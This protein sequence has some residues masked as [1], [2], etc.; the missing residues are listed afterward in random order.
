MADVQ[1]QVRQTLDQFKAQVQE[2]SQGVAALEDLM[3]QVE[4]G[5]TLLEKD[6]QTH[7]ADLDKLFADLQP[8]IADLSTEFD[9]EHQAL[10][11]ATQ[12][13]DGEFG[14]DATTLE[15]EVHQL[16]SEI[17]NYQHALDEHDS[18]LENTH[19]DLHSKAQEMQSKVMQHG[20]GIAEAG[21]ATAQVVVQGVDTHNKALEAAMQAMVNTTLQ[22]MSASTGNLAHMAMDFG[23]LAQTAAGKLGEALKNENSHL[24]ADLENQLKQFESTFNGEVDKLVQKIQDADHAITSEIDKIA[25]LAEHGIDTI[26]IMTHAAEATNVGLNTVTGAVKDVKDILDE[27]GL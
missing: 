4:Q 9:N 7:M 24:N 20:H 11:A 21:N 12:K 14:Q 22:G 23:N 2:A 1:A 10:L 6:M 19:N 3:H 27:I 16:E 18:H 17:Q 25:S 13:V 5:F 8:Q 26:G 15:G